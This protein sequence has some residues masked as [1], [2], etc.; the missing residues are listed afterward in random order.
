MWG[1]TLVVSC[2]VIMWALEDENKNINIFDRYKFNKEGWVSVLLW[3]YV[4]PA[5]LTPVYYLFNLLFK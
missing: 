4:T 1:Y 2:F 5:F 3:L